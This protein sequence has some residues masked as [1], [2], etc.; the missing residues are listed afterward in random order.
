MT[1]FLELNISL[2]KQA[3]FFKSQQYITYI[4][5]DTERIQK[6]LKLYC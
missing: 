1:L 6:D 2:T 3:I 4:N 5:N